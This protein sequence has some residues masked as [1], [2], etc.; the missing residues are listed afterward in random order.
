MPAMMLKVK[1]GRSSSVLQKT[2]LLKM[3]RVMPAK[4]QKAREMARSFF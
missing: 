1:K 2:Y 3:V 4:V